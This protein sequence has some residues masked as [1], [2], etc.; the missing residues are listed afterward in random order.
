MRKWLIILGLVMPVSAFAQVPTHYDL[1]ITGASSST[2]RFAAATTQCNLTGE[3]GAA[4]TINPRY[5]V[6]DDTLTGN[7]RLCMHDT[8]NNTGP[9]FALPIGAYTA[10]L[11]AVVIA[12]TDVLISPP[13]NAV[14]FSRL[15]MPAVRTG[16]RV[17]VAQ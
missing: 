5:L 1:N 17:R 16:F 12:G 11:N 7:G 14:S 13:S 15:T 9:L 6:W 10:V 8:G 3:P 4:G 2:Y